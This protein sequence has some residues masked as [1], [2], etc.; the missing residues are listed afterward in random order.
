MQVSFRSFQRLVFAAAAAAVL[1]LSSPLLA[2][3]YRFSVEP[4]Y[5]P[6]QA[7]EIYAPLIDYLSRST[8]HTFR[9]VVPR[10]YHLLWRDMRKGTEVDFVFED[11]H[12]T[13]FRMQ[14][15]GFVPVARVATQTAFSLIALD[16]VAARGLEGLVGYRIISMPSPSLGYAALGGFYPN[17]ISQPEVQ[18]VAAS[19]RDGVEMVFAGEA[20]AAM[21]P[22]YIAELYPNLTLMQQSQSFPA[23]AV[24][25]AASVPEDVR[26]AVR[27]ALLRMHED[28]SLYSALNEIG[29]VRFEP[30]DPSD[31][32]GRQ[33]MLRGFFGYE[34]P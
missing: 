31:Y 16:D 6:A 18:S 13:D 11:A 34:E 7:E 9:L 17:P 5:P 27:D 24:S 22:N 10:N 25:A 20:E 2:A 33:S 14:R 21:V 3:E 23:R 28:D 15:F 1:L 12:F 29:V 4:E 32:R 30:V 8:G 26:Q 19:W